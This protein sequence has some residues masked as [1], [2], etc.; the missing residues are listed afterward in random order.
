[1]PTRPSDATRPSVTD[2]EVAE[3][4]ALLCDGD[5]MVCQLAPH[6]KWCCFL[7][8]R[9]A[10][11]VEALH[12]HLRS[13]EHRSR[14]ADARGT[15]RVVGPPSPVQQVAQQACRTCTAL[16]A[17]AGV[18]MAACADSP[19][20]VGATRC[21]VYSYQ[22][23]FADRWRA[24]TPRPASVEE[25]VRP[26]GAWGLEACAVEIRRCADEKK[27]SG[28]FTVRRVREGCTVG[29]YAGEQLTQHEYELRHGGEMPA[30][31]ADAAFLR[32]RDERMEQLGDRAPMGGR[33][34]HGA[35]IFEL[36]P[37][38]ARLPRERIAYVDAEDPE[39]SSWCRFINFA[40]AGSA[41]CN[42]KC[43]VDAHRALIWFEATR[44]ISEDEELHFDY[45][46]GG[47]HWIH[48][49]FF[50]VNRTLFEF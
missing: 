21:M 28:A 46:N 4:M 27:G 23:L 20:C 29:V 44:D 45:N 19:A 7:C 8:R 33:Y 49:C 32:E 5:L 22:W 48:R 37:S 11:T 17:A 36:F 26:D 47:A 13:A 43:K 40:P 18:G 2:D 35:Y 10:A 1:M 24:A 31:A 16:A 30:D 50:G 12:A 42:L 38:Y 3:S 41:E 14:E 6:G 25:A 39:R 15:G 34:N 9:Q